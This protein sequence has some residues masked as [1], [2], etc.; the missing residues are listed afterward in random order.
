MPARV[1]AL[2]SVAVKH[3]GCSALTALHARHGMQGP[4]AW[5]T[6]ACS[7]CELLEQ[8]YKAARNGVQTVAVKIFTDQVWGFFWVWTAASPASCLRTWCCAIL[9][10]R[11]HSV[12]LRTSWHSMRAQSPQDCTCTTP[13]TMMH[14]LSPRVRHRLHAL[15]APASMPRI[16]T[17]PK[18][19]AYHAPSRL[20]HR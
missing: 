20:W 3:G 5:H 16:C 12:W 14:V 8:V 6:P 1:H 17:L 10:C 9:G 11:V 19:T 13:H 7:G 15:S 4:L 2:P 18:T